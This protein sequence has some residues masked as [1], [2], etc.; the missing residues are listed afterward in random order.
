MKFTASQIAEILEGEIVGD[1]NIEVSTLAKIEEGSKGSLTF[2]SNE[3]YTSFIYTTKASIA[4]VNKSFEP[5]QE[6]SATLI[7]VEDAYAAFTKLL[8]FYNEVKQN[9]T[10]KEEPHFISDSADLGINIYIGAFAYIGNNV[11]IGDDVKIYP[12]CYI[13]D[14]VTIADGATLFSGVKIYSDCKIGMHCKIHSGAVVGA[15]GFGFA[16]DE[17]KVYTAIPQMKCCH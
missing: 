7:K 11:K 16:P 6:I 17:N 1:P 4:I 10:G 13:G 5:T 3:K 9:K 15:D 12:H 14:N 8:T 2:L